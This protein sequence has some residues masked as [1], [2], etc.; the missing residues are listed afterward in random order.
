MSS[1]PSPPVTP[2]L[3]P[4]A[5]QSLVHSA[6]CPGCILPDVPMPPYPGDL[7]RHGGLEAAAEAPSASRRRLPAVLGSGKPSPR[8]VVPLS[9]INLVVSRRVSGGRLSAPPCPLLQQGQA[10][11]EGTAIAE[12]S[13]RTTGSLR[14]SG[15]SAACSPDAGAW[16]ISPEGGCGNSHDCGSGGCNSG[17]SRS[18]ASSFVMSAT[19]A[20]ERT[21]NF[22]PS[23]G[24]PR[25]QPR[26]LQPRQQQ[27]QQQQQQ[28]TTVSSKRSLPLQLP[29]QLPL[30]VP[31]QVPQQVPLQQLPP[32][33]PP[34][35]PPPPLPLP[36]VSSPP[37]PQYSEYQDSEDEFEPEVT[38]RPDDRAAQC[39]DVGVLLEFDDFDVVEEGDDDS[40][41]SPMLLQGRSGGETLR[42]LDVLADALLSVRSLDRSLRSLSPVPPSLPGQT[43]RPL[44][45]TPLSGRRPSGKWP[46]D[47]GGPLPRPVERREL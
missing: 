44:S 24:S 37:V 30:Q 7:A 46:G 21:C 1:L 28:Q 29:P 27:Q 14:S 15:V 32:E 45:A 18:P 43:R 2:Q 8:V 38:L 3:R 25:R 13:A 31:P 41:E 40:D 17:T 23:F 47:S 9:P 16:P 22:S 12:K 34:P 26:R 6:A 42:E 36:R 19:T 4:A 10:S 5:V 11:P 35:P 33:P 20:A 39:E